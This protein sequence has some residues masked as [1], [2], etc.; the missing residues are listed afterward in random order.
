MCSVATFL[1]GFLVSSSIWLPTY[2][3][4]AYVGCVLIVPLIFRVLGDLWVKACNSLIQKNCSGRKPEA[5]QGTSRK[6]IWFSFIALQVTL[7]ILC[8]IGSIANSNG[9]FS[10]STSAFLSFAIF[11]SLCVAGLVTHGVGGK[12][13]HSNYK[14]YQPFS[15]G[16]A[17][18]V[19]QGMAW[20]LWSASLLAIAVHFLVTSASLMQ[21]CGNC[22][23]KS[24]LNQ[25][26]ILLGASSSGVAGEILLAFSL[27]FF[28]DDTIISKKTKGAFRRA[29]SSP[30]LQKF[31]RPLQSLGRVLSGN[32]L[33]SLQG[34]QAEPHMAASL[35]S[36]PDSPILSPMDM[37]VVPAMMDEKLL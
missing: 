4:A 36:I 7:C 22:L 37:P 32:K 16:T 20:C 35:A 23:L 15:G 6:T 25:G 28:Q 5:S 13:K 2:F 21:F 12:L 1:V 10:E 29:F 8:W 14:F 3:A 24:P 17:F 19:I 26:S 30:S 11:N 27:L 33:S 9:Y 31:A 18:C 34:V